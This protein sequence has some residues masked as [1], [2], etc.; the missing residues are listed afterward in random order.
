MPWVRMKTT[1]PGKRLDNQDFVA[2]STVHLKRR[3]LSLAI[4]CDGVGGRPGGRECAA[5]VGLAVQNETETYF[6]RRRSRKQIGMFDMHA[7]VDRLGRLCLQSSDPESA[8]TMLL[9]VF[10]HRPG[11]NG[12]HILVVWAGDSRAFLAD[13]SGRFQPLTDDHHDDEGRITTFFSG[14]GQL[15]G[16]LSAKLVFNPEP[17][18]LAAT[19]DGIHGGC[20]TSELHF[21][22][23]GCVERMVTDE[24]R[25]AEELKWFLG[26]NIS[27]NF[28]I[29]LIYKP[30]NH[31][32][33]AAIARNLRGER[34]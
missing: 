19:T 3:R 22:L 16:K 30:L 12:Y 24:N 25:L 4:C 10:D 18:A 8:T 2:I 13:K 26:G 33:L 21:F 7:L 17:V 9:V 20:T 27:D 28:S 5:A 34:S 11:N 15:N 6:V 23:L 1:D 14:D 31:C 29:A 32:Q